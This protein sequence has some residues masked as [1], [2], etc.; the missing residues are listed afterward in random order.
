MPT[1]GRRRA[2]GPRRRVRRLRLRPAHL[3]IGNSAPSGWSRGCRSF[4]GTSPRAK[5]SRSARASPASKS[6]IASR[7]IRSVIAGDAVRAARAAS[8]CAPRRPRSPAHSP[9]IRS[10]RS[11]TRTW[12]RPRWTSRQAA[13]LE[14][15]GTGLHAVEQSCSQGGRQ[16]GRRRSGADRAQH[17]ARGARARRD[18]DRDHRARGRRRTPRARAQDGIQDG[19]RQAIATGSSRRARCCRPTAPTCVFDAAGRDRF[20]ARAAAPRR[21]VR[22]SRMAGA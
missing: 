16:R 22:R 2:A 18:L 9:N 7:S 20:A 8:I 11:A 5:W 6:A 19:L 12:F 17:R 13:L 10:R 3:S 4:S 1:P 14:P 21:R 15:F